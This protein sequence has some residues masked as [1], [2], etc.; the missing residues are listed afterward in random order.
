MRIIS[1][2]IFGLFKS[3]YV[4]PKKN[5]IADVNLAPDDAFLGSIN[6]QLECS[7]FS[8]SV[9][10]QMR[11]DIAKKILIK[12][13]VVK[14]LTLYQLSN[15]LPPSGSGVGC[16]YYDEDGNADNKGIAKAMNDYMF[17]VCFNPTVDEQNALHFFDHCLTH[18]TTPFYTGDAEGGLVASKDSITGGLD[19]MAMSRFWL[20]HNDFIRQLVQS[21]SDREVYTSNYSV[22]YTDIMDKVFSTL[23]EMANDEPDAEEILARP[24]SI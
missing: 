14:S 5:F 1:Q 9:S 4:K 20:Q 23:D 3:T 17:D 15:S 2:K 16:G 8:D 13:S 12:R 19:A 18:L 6:C 7:D 11:I 22:K 24:K 21:A 10:P